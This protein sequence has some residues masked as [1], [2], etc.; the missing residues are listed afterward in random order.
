MPRTLG[1]SARPLILAITV[2]GSCV[3]AVTYAIVVPEV[4]PASS[5]EVEFSAERAMRHVREIAQRP[6]PS[7]S[8]EHARL[9]QYLLGELAA[10][11]IP[12]QAQDT[13]GLGT[14]LPGRARSE[15]ARASSG[16]AGGWTRGPSDGALRR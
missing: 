14:R 1:S 10:L 16:H 7:G 3:L 4:I 13:T 5:S 15:R 11:G 2:A 9:R 8:S 6:H 12:A